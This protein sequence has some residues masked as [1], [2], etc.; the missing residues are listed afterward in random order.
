MKP[1]KKFALAEG[2]PFKEGSLSRTL[3]HE[4]G[5][6]LGLDHPDKKTQKVFHRLMGGKKHG[7]KLTDEEIIKARKVA[8]QNK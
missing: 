2:R 5:H 7:Y 3:G 6:L 4:V 1:P 8:E